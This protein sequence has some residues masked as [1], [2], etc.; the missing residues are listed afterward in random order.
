M[1]NRQKLP[2][3]N[4][5]GFGLVEVMISFAIL[6][7]LILVISS[8]LSSARIQETRMSSFLSGTNLA[9]TIG[10]QVTARS[11]TISVINNAA[12]CSAAV[13]PV[14]QS[15]T[16]TLDPFCCSDGT[17]PTYCN[18]ARSAIL[19][20]SYGASKFET[21]SIR[22]AATWARNLFMSCKTANTAPCNTYFANNTA[23]CSGDGLKISG[24]TELQTFFNLLPDPYSYASLP[25]AQQPKELW[26][27]V[28]PVSTSDLAHGLGCAEPATWDSKVAMRMTVT[29]VMND[30]AGTRGDRTSNQSYTMHLTWPND[31]DR[32]KVAA[33]SETIQIGGPDNAVDINPASGLNTDNLTV[34]STTSG[35]YYKDGS[36]RSAAMCT[37][38]RP[39]WGG[40]SQ[41]PDYTYTGWQ[42]LIYQGQSS[43][44]GSTFYCRTGVATNPNQ[45]NQCCDAVN[46]GEYMD[47]STPG[48]AGTV[49]R[50]AWNTAASEGDIISVSVVDAQGNISIPKSFIFSPGYCPATNTYCADGR[51]TGLEGGAQTIA[52]TGPTKCPATATYP[53]YLPNIYCHPHDGCFDFCPT[54]TRTAQSCP[55]S[56][57]TYC[58]VGV[59]L[60]TTNSRGCT[61]VD[62][63]IDVRCA[64]S[65]CDDCGQDTC[66]D[67]SIAVTPVVRAGAYVS[68]IN[69]PTPYL[70]VPAGNGSCPAT[71]AYCPT[72]APNPSSPGGSG[73]TFLPK[74]NCG[75]S[76]PDGTRAAQTCPATTTYC[77]GGNL[78]PRCSGAQCTT[79]NDDCGVTCPA[80][81]IAVGDSCP[82]T[83]GYCS[84]TAPLPATAG[85][86]GPQFLP[87]DTCG[88]DCPAGTRAPATGCPAIVYNPATCPSAPSPAAKDDCGWTCPLTDCT[89]PD[90]AT[91]CAGVAVLD[92]GT[93]LP[94]D[95]GTKVWTNGDYTNWCPDTAFEDTYCDDIYGHHSTIVDSCSDP[96]IWCH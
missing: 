69:F 5:K 60:D 38:N 43:E 85:G 77:S 4:S 32:P 84:P 72:T 71:T 11:Y 50:A 34:N 29:T 21:Q 94:C 15:T 82:A 55:A 22:S 54:G 80:S 10:H 49:V 16:S 12:M 59:N 36:L 79:P 7:S 8:F 61:G 66:A 86:A 92:P 20:G 28:E 51:V 17:N 56:T 78:G 90:P 37:A 39:A 1:E 45:M 14:S 41:Q 88:Q 75:N 64:D 2:V 73:I 87:K 96:N 33:G 52:G 23:I 44:N 93:G 25:V 35:S 89:C 13:V 47:D 18:A 48:G 6:T 19:C 42:K 58:S 27:K 65:T 26:L 81:T 63:T 76:C 57:T 70:G 46:A 95:T 62:C 30:T 24:A 68:T 9:V 74:D 53:A 31:N 91:V 67:S 40:S 83:G 3:M